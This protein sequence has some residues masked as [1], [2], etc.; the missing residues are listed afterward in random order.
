[1][2]P[3]NT[4][5]VKVT[6]RCPTCGESFERYSSQLRGETHHCTPECANA[7]PA[8]RRRGPV[9]KGR[10]GAGH[11]HRRA[12]PR[13]RE[14]RLELGLSLVDLAGRVEV[15]FSFLSLVE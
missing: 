3:T 10:R 1:M 14:R 6:L 9:A 5:S 7:D 8:A 12:L 13:L 4:A 11:R 2:P 15:G